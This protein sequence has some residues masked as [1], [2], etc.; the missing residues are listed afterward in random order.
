MCI[1][2]RNNTWLFE[3]SLLDATEGSHYLD[4]DEVLV[5]RNVTMEIE[6]WYTCRTPSGKEHSAYVAIIGETNPSQLNDSNTLIQSIGQKESPRLYCCF[7]I[8]MS[9]MCLDLLE[10]CRF[11]GVYFVLATIRYSRLCMHIKISY[12]LCRLCDHELI[13]SRYQ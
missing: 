4:M 2:D 7:S 12:C 3:S 1:R 11:Q 13:N 5:I 6:G 9:C 10:F 8:A